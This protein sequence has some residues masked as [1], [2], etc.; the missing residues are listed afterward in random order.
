MLWH[1]VQGCALPGTAYK[2]ISF[3]R[4]DFAQAIP[5]C[6]YPHSTHSANQQRPFIAHAR[7]NGARADREKKSRSRAQGAWAGVVGKYRH[8]LHSVAVVGELA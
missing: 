5:I 6:L 2:H 8:C 3:A 4:L 1:R 7:S